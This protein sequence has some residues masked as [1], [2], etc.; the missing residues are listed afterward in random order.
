MKKILFFVFICVCSYCQGQTLKVVKMDM[1]ASDISAR[2]LARYDINGTPGALIKVQ[3]PR[4]GATFNTPLGILG[5]VK[6][7]NGEY[8]VYVPEKTKQLTVKVSNALPVTVMFGDY[9]IKMVEGKT[10]YVIQIIIEDGVSKFKEKN[11]YFE[12]VM[13]IGGMTAFGV[14]VGGYLNHLNVE[15]SYMMGLTKS[16]EIF[17]NS[18][19]TNTLETGSLSCYTYKPSYF[20]GKVGYAF[21]LGRPFRVTPQVGVGVLSISGTESQ[22]SGKSADAKNGYAINASVSLKVD[23]LILPWLGVGVSPE[24]SLTLSK[25]NLFERVADVSSKIDGYPKGFGIKLGVFFTF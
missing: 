10:N 16:E 9:G 23:Y 1:S 19:N 15:L 22:K 18:T 14:S 7:D 13:Q 12:P 6:D 8:W 17:W 21:Y 25:S 4:K 11:I 3:L 5:D 24:Y 20:G 2:T